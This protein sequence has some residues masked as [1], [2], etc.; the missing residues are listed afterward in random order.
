ASRLSNITTLD[1]AVSDAYNSEGYYD[2]LTVRGYVI[3]NDYNFR[4]DGL[5]INAESLIPLDNKSRVEILKGTSG[6]QAGTSAP[7][8]LV[9]MVVKRPQAVDSTVLSL[10][11]TQPGTVEASI[12]W[13][14]RLSSDV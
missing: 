9:N 12:D 7:G 13:N 2:F 10:G 1:P 5:P 14:K 6:M 8:G 4:R 3:D 11:Y